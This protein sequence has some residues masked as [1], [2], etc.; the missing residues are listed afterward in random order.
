MPQT[1]PRAERTE[2]VA[3]FER[4]EFLTLDQLHVRPQVRREFDEESLQGLA[5]SLE[6]VGQLQPIR[7]RLEDGKYVIVDGE[8]RFRAAKLAGLK[9]LNAVVESRVLK[10]GDIL[11][12]SLISNIQREDLKPL[13]KAE[14][15]SKLMVATGWSASELALKSGVSNGAITR[16]LA[17][18]TLPES[19]RECVACGSINASAA[20]ELSRVEDAG[21]QQELA[22]KLAAGLTRDGLAG[23]IKAQS[24]SPAKGSTK[25]P[26]VATG[27]ATA[28]L[29]EG[30]SV[31]IVGPVLNLQA[32][33]GI[34]EELLLKARKSRPTGIELGTFLALLK[35]QSR[36]A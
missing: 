24:K 3:Q 6:S 22:S 28:H 15:F 17:L 29:G 13:E 23:E 2:D 34:L 7:G 33:I 1:M 36:T 11:L 35:D 25:G 31:T 4:M 27:R 20:Y 5:M 32:V 26:S 21:Q 10:E 19:I 12:Q 30:R 16:S 14:G 9:G 8:R 18:L